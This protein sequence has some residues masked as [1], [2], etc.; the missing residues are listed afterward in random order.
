[1]ESSLA[2]VH[3][4]A[5]ARMATVDGWDLPDVFSTVEAE[6]AAAHDGA[7]VH[8]ASARG[9]LRLTGSSRLDFLHRMSTNDLRA[10]QLG[11]GAATV[12]T[13]PIGRIV[14]RIIVYVRDEDLIV[15]TSRGAQSAVAGWLKKYIFFNDD[16]QIHDVT[17]NHGMLSLFGKRAREAA[18]QLA[19]QDV[20]GL[21]L[22][23]WQPGLEQ[24]IL[25]RADPIAGDGFHLLAAESAPLASLWQRAL[26]AGAAPIGEAVFEVLRIESG[27][28]RYVHELSDAYIPLEAGL[29]ADVSF[30]KGCYIGQEIIARMES[31]QRLAKQLVGLRSDATLHAGAELHAADAAVG[32]VSSAA[33]RP[34]GGSIGLGFVK[35]ASALIGTRLRQASV[36]SDHPIEVV[37]TSLLIPSRG[38]NAA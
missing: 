35:P 37:V 38:S 21:K 6:Y 18:A 24:S 31:R 36:Q 3:R 27:L 25:A 10:L 13:T 1:M 32:K 34:G 15:L 28:P 29:W 7:V 17:L 5:A 2:E 26:E 8:D 16:V 4:Q 30:S 11:Q 22:H 20:S 12:L 23:A 19:G 9:R 33:A 14:D